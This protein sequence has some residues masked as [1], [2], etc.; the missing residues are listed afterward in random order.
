MA[1]CAPNTAFLICR[2]ATKLWEYFY[3]DDAAER[4]R[5]TSIAITL[6]TSGAA[7]WLFAMYR[8]LGTSY[9][10]ARPAPGGTLG[11]LLRQKQGR[12]DRSDCTRTANPRPLADPGPG[13]A[14]RGRTGD[15]GQ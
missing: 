10:G 4:V 9:Q 8:Q 2:Y 14:G 12:I 11:W 6:A 5:Q 15:D 13:G 3:G 7:I 1:A